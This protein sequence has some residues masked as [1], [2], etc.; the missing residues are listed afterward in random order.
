MSSLED[1]VFAAEKGQDPPQMP[2]GDIGM[3]SR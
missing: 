3:P 2:V 1:S